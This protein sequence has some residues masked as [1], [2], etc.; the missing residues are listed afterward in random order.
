M[1][2]RRIGDM[3]IDP[4]VRI[5]IPTRPIYPRLSRIPIIHGIIHRLSL[6]LHWFVV[7]YVSVNREVILFD[8]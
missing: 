1:G 7:E 3:R 5:D 6:P 4:S 2:T 8:M